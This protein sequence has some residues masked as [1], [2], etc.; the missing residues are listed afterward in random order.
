MD[1]SGLNT[2]KPR[3]HMCTLPHMCCACRCWGELLNSL[4]GPYFLGWG[5][6]P[7]NVGEALAPPPC[8]VH[9]PD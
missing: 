6:P 7:A 8:P 4:T 5:L 3:A 2:V 9:L 1:M